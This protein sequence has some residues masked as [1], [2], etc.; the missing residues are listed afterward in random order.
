M[1]DT[2]TVLRIYALLTGLGGLIIAILAPTW[3][4]TAVSAR[5]FGALLIGTGCWA[6]TLSQM[7]DPALRRRALVLFAVGHITML[8]VVHNKHIPIWRPALAPRVELAM[9][10]E[11]LVI[12]L[13]LIYGERRFM[14]SRRREQATGELTIEPLRSRYEQQIHRAGAQEERNRLARDLHDSIKQQIFIIQTAA[15][16]AQARFDG[17]QPGAALAIEQ[18]RS[19]ARDAMTEME[20]MMDQLRSVPLENAGLI[21]AVRRQCEALGHRTGALVQFIPGTLPPDKTLP[22]GAHQAILRVAQ[23]ACANIGRHARAQNVVVSLAETDKSVTLR[24]KDDG[25]GFDATQN[26]GGM[27]IANMRSRA[28][29]LGGSFHVNTRPGD[30]TT[31][32]FSVPIMPP[33]RDGYR[34]QL[35]MH[36]VLMSVIGATAVYYVPRRERLFAVAAWGI[37]LTIQIVRDMFHWAERD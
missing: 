29:E 22:P 18:V 2:R 33:A 11:F 9:S 12:L 25:A 10:V 37:A 6:G 1:P 8:F 36:A 30:G 35:L 21:D 28:R 27:G 5:L 16:T 3:F 15:A 24:I 19:A 32:T 26:R 34:M 17:D 31:V 23:E 14:E 4:G 20:V 7:D 13:M